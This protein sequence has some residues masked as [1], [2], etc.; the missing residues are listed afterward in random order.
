MIKKFINI[1]YL[2]NNKKIGSSSYCISNRICDLYN[3]EVSP[4]YRNNSIGSKL[5]RDIELDCYTKN[6]D[7]ISLV[8]YNKENN[9]LSDFY[10]KK[11]IF[12][13]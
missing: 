12:I 3:I 1:K 13:C 8:S 7:K 9:N 11:W 10:L 6:V 4:E 2:I 5:L